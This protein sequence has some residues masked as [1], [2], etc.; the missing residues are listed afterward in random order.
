[1]NAVQITDSRQT[2]LVRD[3]AHKPQLSQC[4]AMTIMGVKLIMLPAPVILLSLLIAC[5]HKPP[6]I[7]NGNSGKPIG[8]QSTTATPSADAQA[9]FAAVNSSDVASVRRVLAKSLSPNQRDSSGFTPLM[10]SSIR[11][12]KEITQILLT[13]GADVNSKNERGETVLLDATSS[14]RAEI[15]ELLLASGAD[16]SAIDRDLHRTA[17]HIA[18]ANGDL[19]TVKALLPKVQDVNVRDREGQTPLLVTG[20][21]SLEIIDLLIDHGADVNARNKYGGT[22]L[23]GAVWNIKVVETLLRHG[24]DV[25]AKDND[26]WTPLEQAL[27]RG[28]PEVIQLLEKAG[29]KE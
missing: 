28:C 14:R 26:G 23:M 1:M 16:I 20:E 6:A 4:I 18:C 12:D 25:N 27:L 24:A 8:Q 22:A 29:A 10:T 19:A 11:G 21:D 9:L 5:V 7:N 2:T 13:A 17:L 15:V 3:S